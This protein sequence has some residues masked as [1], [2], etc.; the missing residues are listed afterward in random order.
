MRALIVPVVASSTEG[1]AELAKQLPI[2]AD[3]EST[4]S[5]RIEIALADS[6]CVTIDQDVDV[7]MIP[8][9]IWARVWLAPG[10]TDMRHGM[11]TLAFVDQAFRR[12]FAGALSRVDNHGIQNPITGAEPGYPVPFE[13]P[14]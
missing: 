13:T 5:G 7:A 2:P 14:L 1:S 6:S 10:V 4:P 8:P 3:S 9:P 11:N 12:C